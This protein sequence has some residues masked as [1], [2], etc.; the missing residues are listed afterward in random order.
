VTAASYA[1]VL[2]RLVSARRFGVKLGL[3]RMRALLDALGAPDTQ[4]GTVIHVAGTNGKG[5]TVAMLAA[6]AGSGG[7]RVATY[8][9]PH[10]TTLRERIS[11]DG[12]LVTEAQIVAAYA[13]VEAA[14]GAELTFFE[15]VT[16]IA[17]VLIAE[18]KADITVLEVG[19]GGRLD[20]T[21]CVAADIAVITGVAFDHE[22]ILGNTLDAIA[23]EK[24]GICKP[25]QPV[26]IGA[27][28]EPDGVPLLVAHARAAG[29]REPIAVAPDTFVPVVGLAGAHQRRN[30]ALALE[31]MR[32]LGKPFDAGALATVRHPG[33]FEVLEDRR[34]ILDGAH[35]PHG[36]RALGSAL[37]DRRGTRDVRPVIV[38]AV[39]AD[40]DIREI[41]SALLP[42]AAA[43][44]ATRFQQERAAHPEALAEVLREVS[45]TLGLAVPVTA[46]PDFTSA[47]AA[48]RAHGGWTVVA[49]S[50]FIV[51][52]AR[53]AELGAP[54]D[55]VVATD[56]VAVRT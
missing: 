34:L 41:A 36:A 3:D 20:A 56:P 52:E 39:S 23:F 8:T 1:D 15:Q 7:A 54:A 45:A 29:A 12:A 42:E 2:G 26:V 47:L 49:G 44:I 46:A 11:I 40:K 50:L 32:T 48:A 33:R 18:A 31:V 21:N 13:R 37:R 17:L 6:L 28:G 35:N 30:A 4:L 27:C 38:L 43:V 19:L 24:A 22:A 10:L 5:S 55:P 25:D 16:A 51:G 14:G 53:V 9:S